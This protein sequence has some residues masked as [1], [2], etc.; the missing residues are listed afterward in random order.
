MAIIEAGPAAWF[1]NCE[2]VNTVR[3]FKLKPT[4]RMLFAQTIGY[5]D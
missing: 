5:P 4:Q 1:H 2:K 3:E